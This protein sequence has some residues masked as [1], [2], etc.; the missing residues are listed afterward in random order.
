LLLFDERA[1]FVCRAEIGIDPA[2]PVA[3]EGEKLRI[4]E[5]LAAFG[6]AP[7]GHKHLIAFRGDFLEFVALDPAAVAPAALE[8]G[9]L[10]DF[11]VIR[12]REAEIVGE[13]ILTT[14]RSFDM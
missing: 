5:I 14:L 3:F 4:P 12:T 8:I 11:V 6:Y 2:D 1:I 13:C 10:V 7:I 9:R